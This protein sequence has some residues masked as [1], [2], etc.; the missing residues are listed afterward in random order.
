[1]IFWSIKHF[2]Q[3]LTSGF[4][5]T[6]IVVDFCTNNQNICQVQPELIVLA[7]LCFVYLWIKIFLKSNCSNKINLPTC[8]I[9]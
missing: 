7:S 8:H 4:C 6:T 1:M 3:I 2:N 5:K 9:N